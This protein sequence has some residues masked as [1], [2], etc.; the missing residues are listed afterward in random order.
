MISSN[1]VTPQHSSKPETSTKLAKLPG[2][3]SIP[4]V[5]EEHFSLFRA[6]TTNH[7]LQRT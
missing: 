1:P 3:L 4:L 6:T 5:S 2:A 7:F